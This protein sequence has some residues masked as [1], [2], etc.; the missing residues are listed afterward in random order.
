M[1][2]KLIWI[3]VPILLA[4]VCVVGTLAYLIDEEKA[5]NVM[6]VGN[7]GIQIV[8]Y[9]REST[10]ASNDAATVRDFNG[11]KLLLPSTAPDNFDYTALDNTTYVDWA[12]VGKT[13]Y[14]SPIWDPTKVSNEVDKMVFVENTGDYDAYDRLYFA[15]E[16]GNFVRLNRFKEM[17]HLNLDTANWTW[18]WLDKENHVADIGGAKYFIAMATCNVP[19]KAGELSPISL[20]QIALDPTAKNGDSLAFGE[21]YD[22]LV[23]AQGIQADGF[24]SDLGYTPATALDEG[25][26]N[27]IPFKNVEDVTFA[28]LRTALSY[29][30]ADKTSEIK[31]TGK[32]DKNR[33]KVVNTVTFGLT[34][35][36]AD[37]VKDYKGVF[38]ANNSG[39]ADFTA[40]VYYV[41]FGNDQYDI[42]VLADDWKICAPNDSSALFKGMDSLKKVDTANLDV[43]GV[44]N[45]SAMFQYCGS[46]A[47]IDVSHWDVSKV[48]NVSYMFEKCSV[49]T[50]LAVDAWA[51]HL[52]GRKLNVAG[53]FLN[54]PKLV[55]ADV[56]D[57]NIIVNGTMQSMFENCNVLSTPLD[58]SGWDVSGVTSM[59]KTF[60]YCYAL[61]SLNVSG[62]NVE[63]STTFYHMF[64]GCGKLTELAVADWNVS[65]AEGIAFDSMFRNCGKLESLDLSKW[66]FDEKITT[67]FQMFENCASLTTL[68]VS[69]WG[70]KVSGVTNIKRMFYGCKKLKTLSVS[71]W[72]VDKVTNMGEVFSGC[73]S[74]TQLDLSGWNT[75]M[76]TNVRG[77]FMNCE[78]L[79]KI[80]VGDNWKVSDNIPETGGNTGN[81]Q[82]SEY[83]FVNCFALVGGN[84]TIYNESKTNKEYAI[85][86]DT[87]G[88]PGYLTEK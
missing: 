50:E 83:M 75:N 5:E 42:Y 43:S 77:M 65:K 47:E 24:T 78:K 72:K 39:E 8:E 27:D 17:V 6:T 2:K 62:W 19:V 4:V 82:N 36:H 86:D 28:D 3:V 53:I 46:L 63:N 10:S 55:S 41:P 54:C 20:S 1:K 49:L 32:D 56:S 35:E 25:F 37:K 44:A 18:E 80:Y 87:D 85:V 12:Q 13:G 22:V 70:N 23:F 14:T 38:I 73:S 51:D 40:Y 45:M 71:D 48:T 60:M 33:S 79:E 11:D 84:G 57:W 31:L 26:G 30:N 9:E 74:L 68:D 66:D 15:F 69:T 61:P 58:L 52:S 7:V 64:D 59:G 34:E 16:A 76:V 81:A 67:C 21:K 88:K 29:L